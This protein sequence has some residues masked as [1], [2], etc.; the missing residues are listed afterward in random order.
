MPVN[1]SG[2]LLEFD[3]TCTALV[4]PDPWN[5]LVSNR[6]A[7]R[8]LP[9]GPPPPVRAAANLLTLVHAARLNQVPVLISPHHYYPADHGWKLEAGLEQMLRR[10]GMFQPRGPWI[11]DAL[12]AD[13]DDEF[14][15]LFGS[16]NG[17]ESMGLTLELERQGIYRILLAGL[18]AD[19]SLR[20]HLSELR[21]HGFQVGLVHDATGLV[22]IL[23]NRVYPPRVRLPDDSLFTTRDV[24][25]VLQQGSIH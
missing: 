25:S 6:G 22:E 12:A 24:V 3:P 20:G 4:I 18:T 16:L 19:L 2:T 17:R 21:E 14:D 8:S 13:P 5:R 15:D 9:W 23:G 1:P 10:V 11:L 7:F